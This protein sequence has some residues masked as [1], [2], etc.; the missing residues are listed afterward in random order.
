MTLLILDDGAVSAAKW[1]HV[2][3]GVSQP[4]NLQS[5]PVSA[6]GDVSEGYTRGAAE[7]MLSFR[8]TRLPLTLMSHVKP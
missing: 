4:T 3:E 2:A 5:T 7:A 8:W 6:S 1:L